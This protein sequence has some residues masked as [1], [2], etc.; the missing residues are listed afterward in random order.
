[1]D[2]F[3]FLSSISSTNKHLTALSTLTPAYR[4][5]GT[6]FGNKT[7]GQ[8]RTSVVGNPINTWRRS[9]DDNN[10]S[11]VETRIDLKSKLSNQNKEIEKD[12]ESARKI[13]EES[14]IPYDINGKLK[15]QYFDSMAVATQTDNQNPNENQEG[16]PTI[17]VSQ[18]GLVGLTTTLTLTGIAGIYPTN[19][20]TTSY[21]PS[22]FKQENIFWIFN[23]TQ[24][25]SAE[26]WTTQIEGRLA[27]KNRGS[28]E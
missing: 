27:W 9:G 16:K 10:S 21:L 15:S 25:C 26:T 8:Y 18:Y 17:K 5:F 28:N 11:D 6:S 13:F 2:I 19:A 1:M 23:T 24:N 3:S 22:L 4:K 14:P 20:F 7:S 12:L